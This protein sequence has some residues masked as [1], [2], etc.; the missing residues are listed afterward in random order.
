[1]AAIIGFKRSKK[2]DFHALIITATPSGSLRTLAFLK[3]PA[4]ICQRRSYT[5]FNHN[6]SIA[7]DEAGVGNAVG[8]L[9]FQMRDVLDYILF[10]PQDPIY[11]F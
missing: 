5:D 2:G 7:E 10:P 3:V 8:S 1:M 4:I 11:A 9:F 6:H